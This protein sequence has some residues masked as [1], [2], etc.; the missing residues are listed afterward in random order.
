[1]GLW[2]IGYHAAST[3]WSGSSLP[4]A[5]RADNIL[6]RLL[7]EPRLRKGNIIFV[8]HSMGGLI[9]EQL[10]RSAERDEEINSIA[11]SLLKR[12]RR[13]AFL[14]TPHRGSLFANLAKLLPFF[15]PSDA[16]K[17]LPMG[18]P[19]LKDLNRWY[20]RFCQA[21]SI[22]NLLLAEGLSEKK[23]GFRI[24]KIVSG[25]SADAGLA[26]FTITV[27]ETHKT[28]AK[29]TDKTSQVY[30][31]VKEF[32]SRPFDKPPHA[33][34]SIVGAVE[35]Q[36]TKI[37]DLGN[38]TAKN[39]AVL[40]ELTRRVIDA[41]STSIVDTSLVDKEISRLLGNLIKRRLFTNAETIDHCR[42]FLEELT[43]G[44]L[45]CGSISSKDEAFAWCARLLSSDHVEEAQAALNA[46]RNR[47]TMLWRVAKAFID[48]TQGNQEAA[49][50]E[51]N[52]AAT[53]YRGAAFICQFKKLGFNGAKA[54][55]NDAELSF[56]NL[57]SDGKFFFLGWAQ[58]TG[59]WTAAFESL[60]SIEETDFDRTPALLVAAASTHLA[61]ATPDELRAQSLSYVPI[62]AATFPLRSEPANL[63]HRRKA[64]LLFGR[65]EVA[66]HELDLPAAAAFA[67]DMALWLRLVDPETG[68]GA[69]EHLSDSLRDSAM[70]LRRA[71]LA[72]QFGIN[73]DLARVEREVDR[74][75]ALTGGAS[76]EA[77]VARFSLALSQK[78]SASAADYLAK[79]RDQLL[80]HIDPK[81]VYSFE[82]EA[83]A[84]AGQRAQALVRLEEAST[85]GLSADKV[86]WLRTLLDEFAAND[87]TALRLES[88]NHT[89]SVSDL[90]LLVDCYMGS[91]DWENVVSYGKILLEKTGDLAEARRY[92][93]ALY[94]LSQFDN[95][96]AVIES[97]PAL[98]QKYDDL[99]VFK[100]QI[101]YEQG[102]ILQARIAL[103]E[104]RRNGES[105]NS[106]QLMVNLAIASGD[107]DSLQAF[108]EQQWTT[109]DSLSADEL[110]GAGQIAQFIGVRRGEDLVKEAAN[111]SV[112]DA[113]RLIACYNAATKGGWELRKEAGAWLQRAALLSEQMINGP[114]Q[115]MTL[116]DLAE[117]Q[118]AWEKQE[119]DTW[120]HLTKGELPLMAVGNILNRTLI[121]LFLLP[122]IGNQ[123]EKDV[124]KR[125]YVHAFSGTRLT[126]DSEPRSLAL[127]P[128]ALITAELL[129]LLE[130]YISHFEQIYIP[131]GTLR[132]LL[133]ERA[134]T[135]FHQPSRVAASRD[136]KRLIATGHLKAFEGS[137]SPSDRLID[138][139]GESLAE[140]LTAAL[141]ESQPH[142][143]QRLVVCAGPIYRASTFMQ[144]EADISP[145]LDHICGCINVIDKLLQKGVLTSVEA[146]EAKLF[147]SVREISWPKAPEIE[148]GAILYLDNAAAA[149]LEYLGLLS[150]IQLAGL[151]AVLSQSK[152]KEADAL[153]AYDAK[154]AEVLEVVDRLRN[155][156]TKGIQDG[157]V[158]L[159]SAVRIDDQD[160]PHGLAAHP[161][162]DMLQLVSKVDAGVSDDRFLNKHN[163]IQFGPEAKPLLTSLD[164]LDI[165]HRR[166]VI[167]SA[168]KSH[169]RTTLRR[170]GYTL[171]PVSA[172]ELKQLIE[173][174]QVSKERLIETAELKALRENIQRI[175]MGD[176]LQFPKEMAW[177]NNLFSV[178]I[179]V[180]RAQWKPGVAETVAA[181]KSDW[182]LALGDVKSWT[183]CIKETLPQLNQRYKTALGVLMVLPLMQPEEVKAAY[184]SWFSSRILDQIMEEDPVMRAYLVE[185]AKSLVSDFA[186]YTADTQVV[187][188]G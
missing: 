87:S 137:S 27:D 187:N 167:T 3:N 58:S 37:A 76:V 154:A 48:H 20:R 143:S 2:L 121:S 47:D 86:Q 178:A 70:L 51:L 74:Q 185:R 53:E 110:L 130:I 64:A 131:H 6:A 147:I 78:D 17:D 141:A 111:R 80:R 18:S 182:L 99:P 92:T 34:E 10:L 161:T 169:A 24:G 107:W 97:Y 122:A 31:Q 21:N 45:A 105:S 82:V 63:E 40:S 25:D 22:E 162:S 14:G 98:L 44:S 160:D 4:L 127:E 11:R 113:N 152:V 52:F 156:L 102:D 126:L 68:N 54:W 61:H 112:D 75:T 128:T 118:P 184:W 73:V 142:S 72:V 7:A 104:A 88:Y 119:F 43:K 35:K 77:A 33:S 135:L 176:L 26:E 144:E 186:S 83:L 29:P 57:D 124:R 32:I 67:G 66:A 115:R 71:N 146:D 39:T 172:E 90:H 155:R 114:V 101:L 109:R 153:I 170:A 36:A 100:A 158:R 106:R 62:N 188:H 84:R 81:A 12:T 30:I 117:R 60:D 15:R 42:R 23:W 157:K 16:T 46:I 133:R 179:E 13:V 91:E 148:D 145:F 183:H 89:Q 85:R 69:R 120:N 149:H 171:V 79:H 139:V 8:A 140:L 65:A 163:F 175:R 19:Q 168:Q 9:V 94:K 134:E 49:L 95:A 50:A 164:I 59:D 181:A 55:L 173:V 1:M 41:N 151:F 138:E 93:Y 165:L 150:K 56:S 129:G 28:I 103:T 177:L 108:V 136:L 96:L 38:E 174:A 125:P 123:S 180:L 159:G 132:W 166:L 5:D 116:D